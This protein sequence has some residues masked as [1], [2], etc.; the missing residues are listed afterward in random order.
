MPSSC[1]MFLGTG[2]P[3]DCCMKRS[4]PPSGRLFPGTSWS[5][6]LGADPVAEWVTLPLVI[7]A[8]HMAVHLRPSSPQPEKTTQMETQMLPGSSCSRH[9]GSPPVDR[10][11]LSSLLPSLQSFVKNKKSFKSWI[12]HKC[13]HTHP[14]YNLA[15]TVVDLLYNWKMWI[16]ILKQKHKMLN[17]KAAGFQATN[18]TI[19]TV[20]VTKVE[21]T[22]S[23]ICAVPETVHGSRNEWRPSCPNTLSAPRQGGEMARM[24]YWG[25]RLFHTWET[26]KIRWLYNYLFNSTLCI[27]A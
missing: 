15:L 10:S 27:L 23:Q 13:V 20:S 25:G 11:Y 4:K 17:T 8:S 6:V 18:N 2:E 1:S 16:Y 26:T 3:W 19:S 7:L 9:P 5:S 12:Q 24:G 14:H 21:R 22:N